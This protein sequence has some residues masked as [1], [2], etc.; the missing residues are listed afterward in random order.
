MVRGQVATIPSGTAVLLTTLS[1]EQK[2]SM[3]ILNPNDGVIYLR[4]NGP[5]SLATTN[6]DWK[7]PSQSYGQYPGPWQSIGLWYQ[8]Q[9]GSNAAGQINLYESDAELAIPSIVAIGRAA[10]VAGTTV[11]IT[12]GT[13][14][15]SPPQNTSRLWV[16]TT[17]TLHL[18][19]SN[20][21]DRVEID[22]NNINSYV[23]PLI[24]ATALGG[25][26]YG[27]IPNG[28][29]W[30]HTNPVQLDRTVNV[31]WGTNSNMDRI[32]L[33]SDSN[34]Y[35]D[36]TG[37]C[38]I[39]PGGTTVLAVSSS[40]AVITGNGTITGA[41]VINGGAT[42][43][44][45]MTVHNDIHTDR[46]NNSGVVYFGNSGSQYLFYDGTNWQ[47][48]GGGQLSY[49]GTYSGPQVNASSQ[50]QSPNF[51]FPDGAYI[52]NSGGY[53]YIRCSG[54]H[55]NGIVVQTTGGANA[56]VNCS[57]IV[58]N[59]D[60]F[61]VDQG[62]GGYGFCCRDTNVMIR[63]PVSANYMELRS[64]DQ[65]ME[66][67]DA[68]GNAFFSIR[69]S[70]QTDHYGVNGSTN[71]RFFHLDTSWMGTQAANF[72]V[73]SDIRF[74]TNVVEVSDADCLAR[75]KTPNIPVI[76]WTPD[77][78][79]PDSPSLR[80]I[81]FSAQD[82]QKATPETVTVDADGNYFLSYGNLTAVLWGALRLIE[83]RLS[84]LETHH[85]DMGGNSP[86]SYG[87]VAANVAP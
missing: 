17:G 21:N 65:R 61:T 18:V 53:I 67:C 29:V 82:M 13:I 70:G 41:G 10:Q 30:A 51:G 72:Q 1:R 16:D 28:H 55:N 87:V 60:Q 62:N 58:G 26:L 35:I 48:T 50:V 79:M 2:N 66:F 38:N 24:A 40:G 22:S 32:V 36:V 52:I 42:I 57:G 43:S 54:A 59:G 20:G 74:K 81:G 11:D 64:Y 25:D 5:A 56:M 19:D 86:P 85:H 23:N 78:P 80:D 14:P 49:G 77:N 37:V 34:M 73:Q 75:L 3:A 76:T 69:N 39:R 9:S 7:L 44:N 45:G 4:L 31:Q 83:S 71:H 27:T 46:N 84:T 33:W 15:Q 63:R 6:W 8:D 47:L 68:S 12:Q